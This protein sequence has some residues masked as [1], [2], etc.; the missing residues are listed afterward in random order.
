MTLG[1]IYVSQ[2]IFKELRNKN[3]IVAKED[4]ST[5]CDGSADNLIKNLL[6][7][8][9]IFPIGER[10]DLHDYIEAQKLLRN[11][12]LGILYLLLTDNCNLGCKYCYI[13]NKIPANYEFQLMTNGIVNKALKIFSKFCSSAIEEPQIVFYGGEPLLNKDVFYFAV[14]E[15]LDM[16][17]KNILPENLGITVNTNAT[18]ADEKFCRFVKDKPIQI[19]VSIDGNIEKDVHDQMRTYKDGSGSFDNAI[20]GCRLMAENGINFSF[21]VTA[22]KANIDKMPAILNWFYDEFGIDSIGWFPA[23]R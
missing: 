7:K 17:E 14:K 16:Q 15:I 10:Y 13:E 12:G 11:N 19:S 2:K 6:D 4:L 18:L 3:N 9:F 22:T 20:K 5:C 23:V 21:S 1:V 8:R